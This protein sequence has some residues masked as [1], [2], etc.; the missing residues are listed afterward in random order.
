MTTVGMAQAEARSPEAHLGL[1]SERSPQG[2]LTW[3]AGIP[4]SQPRCQMPTPQSAF[5]THASLV[6]LMAPRT[7]VNAQEILIG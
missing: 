4:V 1:P 2:S 6:H 7:M 3:D 5:Y